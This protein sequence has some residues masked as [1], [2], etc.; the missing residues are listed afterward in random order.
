LL[1]F[2]GNDLWLITNEVDKLMAFKNKEAITTNDVK[3]YV[4]A[5]LNENI[6]GLSDALASNNKKEAIKLLREQLA[7]GLNEVYL[8]TM[9]TRQFRILTEIKSLLSQ[10]ISQTQITSKLKLHPYV[11]KKSLTPAQKFTLLKLQDIYQKL[12]EL[13]KKIKSTSLPAQTLLN[14]FILQI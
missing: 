1:S 10:N 14:L 13:E 12:V 8:L 11:V 2:L 7:L 9:I 6:F 3:Q 4:T 5:K